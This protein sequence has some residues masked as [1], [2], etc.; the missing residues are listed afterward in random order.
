M[1]LRHELINKF[2]NVQLV[3][4]D[5]DGVLTDGSMYYSDKGEELK[6]FHTRDGMAVEL[7]RKQK[8]PTILIT[9]EKS[10]IASIRATKIKAKIYSGIQKKESLVPKLCKQF[11]VKPENIAYIGDDINDYNI[12]KLVGLAI[13]PSDAVTAIKEIAHYTCNAKGGKGVLRETAELI[14]HYKGLNLYKRH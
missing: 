12:M 14:I 6:K 7:L 5:V 11:N 8:L 10:K 2:Q 13:A 4:T 9:K 1:K 3:A